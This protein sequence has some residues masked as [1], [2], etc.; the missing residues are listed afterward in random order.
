M[1]AILIDPSNKT[2]TDVDYDGDYQKI[3]SI[4]GASSGLFDVVRSGD[5][6]IMYI[7]DEG[8][9]VNPNPHG[10]FRIGNFPNTFAGKGLVV[11]VRLDADGAHDTD[12]SRGADELTRFV[13][14]IDNPDE[15][16]ID[17]AITVTSF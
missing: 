7:D 3:A 15:A 13:R 11:G 16:S 9:L 17:P 12:I 4:I 6:A 14:F 5:D 1:K 2:V 10:Y 8:L